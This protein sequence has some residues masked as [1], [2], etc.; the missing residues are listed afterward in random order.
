MRSGFAGGTTADRATATVLTT[1]HIN[2][3]ERC[4]RDAAIAQSPFRKWWGVIRYVLVE[5][6][7]VWVETTFVLDG[8]YYGLAV[9]QRIYEDWVQTIPGWI[10]VLVAQEQVR[11]LDKEMILS[12]RGRSSLRAAQ[13]GGGDS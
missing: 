13:H 4:A 8:W 12:E 7:T 1:E 2:M 6:S 10:V 5:G 3:I 9:A 11:R